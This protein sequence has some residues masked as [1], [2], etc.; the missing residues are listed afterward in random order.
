[1]LLYG[2]ANRDETEFTEPDTVI[3]DRHPNR[4]LG[5]GMGPHRCLGSHLAKLQMKLALQRILPVLGD[6]QIEDPAKITWK[7]ASSRGM[8]SLPL[9]RKLT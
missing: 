5:F 6:W 2:S 7:A 3:L 1:M 8:S 4:H 9:V